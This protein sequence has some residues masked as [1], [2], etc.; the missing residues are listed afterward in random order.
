MFVDTVLPVKHN[1]VQ[2]QVESTTLND[3][4]RSG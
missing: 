2:L 4:R 3:D 1:V